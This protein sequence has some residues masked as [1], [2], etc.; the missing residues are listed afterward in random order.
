MRKGLQGFL[1]LSGSSLGG[2]QRKTGKPY[3]QLGDLLIHPVY[4]YTVL[5]VHHGIRKSDHLLRSARF[6]YWIAKLVRADS[7]VCTRAGLLHDIYS[8]M[9][10]WATHGAIAASVA[11]QMGE[12]EQVCNAIETHM[13]PVGPVPTSKEGWVLVV[14]DK[15]ATFTDALHFLSLLVAGQGLRNRRVLRVT[16]PFMATSKPHRTLRLRTKR[17]L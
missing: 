4:S 10:T 17:T 2:Y 1:P 9:G 15:M 8:R 6:A 13:F 12:S 7:R 11:R 3:Q 14:A 16:D 5:Q